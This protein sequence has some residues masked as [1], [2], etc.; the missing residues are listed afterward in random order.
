MNLRIPKN[1]VMR[2]GILLFVGTTINDPSVIPKFIIRN[3]VANVNVFSDTRPQLNCDCT[4]YMD[5]Y[6]HEGSG[7]FDGKF[8]FNGLIILE[9]LLSNKV[10]M[11]DEMLICLYE[12]IV[13]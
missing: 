5:M 2:T 7:G 6:S 12:G 10:I 3:G 4:V 8:S 11:I 9:D 1:V 13:N